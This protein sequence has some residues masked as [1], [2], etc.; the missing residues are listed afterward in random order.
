MQ[1]NNT[2]KTPAHTINA[3]ILRMTSIALYVTAMRNLPEL[4]S[5]ILFFSK[6]P[7]ILMYL[8]T[9]IGKGK[10]INDSYLRLFSIIVLFIFIL[11][12]ILKTLTAEIA[13]DT[14]WFHFFFCQI[15]YCIGSVRASII[16]GAYTN[17]DYK[18]D[19]VIP[20]EESLLIAKET[21]PS[22][23]AS[24]IA[25][26]IGF[27]LIFSRIQNNFD[28]MYLQAIG[29]LLYFYLPY[30]LESYSIHM[31]VYKTSAYVFLM[32]FVCFIGDRFSCLIF[33]TILKTMISI[34]FI[35]LKIIDWSFLNDWISE[36]VIYFN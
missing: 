31:S 12:P 9:T 16:G 28:I 11:L 1:F 30:F 6:D 5:T 13:T 26:V 24:S 7:F 25:A 27:I 14:I 17:R 34:L 36:T 20:L 3:T 35:I 19:H 21:V 18:R 8:C 2:M 4:K 33:T 10:L 32:A 15:V 22:N 29:F 23:A